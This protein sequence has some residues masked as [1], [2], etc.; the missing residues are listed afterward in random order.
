VII[1]PGSFYTSLMPIFAVNGVREALAGVRGPVVLVANLLTEGRGMTG[2]TAADAVRK[3]EHAIGRPV[4]ALV[5]NDGTP[6]ADVL[7]RY[8]A[9]HKLPLELGDLP[10]TCRLISGCFWRR[11]I[12]RHDRPRLAHALWAVLS[13]TMVRDA[14]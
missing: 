7:E 11:E 12:A 5:F 4:D 10:A 13:T 6:A 2:F 14:R 9:E 8:A 1:G 3:L